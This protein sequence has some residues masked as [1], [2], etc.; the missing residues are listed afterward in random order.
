MTSYEKQQCENIIT[1]AKTL[2]G[3][4]GSNL[5]LATIMTDMTIEIGYVFGYDVSSKM[6]SDLKEN[7]FS[8]S[9]GS[10]ANKLLTG[11]IP[12]VGTAVN[13]ASAALCTEEC[14]WNA[15]KFFDSLD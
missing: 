13:H 2:A 3:L 6:P 11:W 9:A 5:T 8:Y 7:I 10:T 12:F 1:K 14:G 4:K 15:A